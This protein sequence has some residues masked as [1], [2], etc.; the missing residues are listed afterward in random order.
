MSNKI[1]IVQVLGL[2][3]QDRKQKIVDHLSFTGYSGEVLGIFGE[4]EKGKTTILKIIAG[5]SKKEEGTIIL[6]GYDFDYDQ[7]EAKK[8]IQTMIQ[9]PYFSNKVT[10]AEYLE[11]AIKEKGISK[12]RLDKI[13]ELL[14]GKV[15]LSEKIKGYSKEKKLSLL[16]GEMLL[17]S[18]KLILLEEPMKG[19]SV[20]EIRRMRELLQ[21]IAHEWDLCIMVTDSRLWDVDKLCDRV[22]FLWQG[23]GIGTVSK[24]ELLE[25]NKS[26]EDFYVEQRTYYAQKEELLQPGCMV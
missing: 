12:E 16:L 11:R 8:A 5:L 9:L 15:N 3:K 4:S 18:P 19:F 13:V 25:K 2:T 24:K 10:G 22:L 7:A 26:I 17:N 6:N 23:K 1:I 14:R 20:L 21:E